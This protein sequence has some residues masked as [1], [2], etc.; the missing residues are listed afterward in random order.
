MWIKD[1]VDK[2]SKPSFE[3]TLMHLASYHTRL[4]TSDDYHS[5][6]IWVREQ[7]NLMGYSTAIEPVAILGQGQQ[8][9]N[10]YG[11]KKG[12][13]SESRDIVVVTAHLD[14]VNHEDGPLG[15]APG[16]DD[17]GSG[18]A[19]LLEIAR[20]FRD[21]KTQQ[22]LRFIFFGGEEQGLIGSK[23]YVTNLSTAERSRIIAI[24]NMDMIGI[25]NTTPASVLLEGAP[26]SQSIIDGLKEAA[27]T[28]STLQVEISLQPWGSD[29]VPF[30]DAGMP[31]VLTIE[32]SDQVNINE[33]S[34]RDK[35]DHIDMDFALE[36]VRM[37]TAFLSQQLGS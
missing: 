12:I 13:S 20:V 30:I 10:I 4:S 36:I 18:S 34:A 14:S 25:L 27:H 16:A 7:L 35:I 31:A 24:I 17:N 8:S 37:N 1:L 28:Y 32:G 33:H 19:G 6:A 5:S 11:E 9:Y 22:D 26:I 3:A 2:V 23:Q 15:S 21:H 29:H